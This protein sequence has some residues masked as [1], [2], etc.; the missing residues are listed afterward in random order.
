M[1]KEIRIEMNRLLVLS[2]CTVDN[3]YTIT[4]EM[5]TRIRLARMVRHSRMNFWQLDSPRLPQFMSSG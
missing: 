3:E 1:A 4:N 2:F 5:P